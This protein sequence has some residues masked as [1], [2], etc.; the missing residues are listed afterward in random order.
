VEGAQTGLG[1]TKFLAGTGFCVI[2]PT[3]ERTRAG[4]GYGSLVRAVPL[5][6]E[7]TNRTGKDQLVLT[8]AW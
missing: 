2:T 5:G 8:D 7:T 1:S 6:Q 3:L 4:R